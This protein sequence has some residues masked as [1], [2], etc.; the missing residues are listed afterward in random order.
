MIP[1]IGLVG[2]GHWSNRMHVPAAQRVQASGLARYAAV[3]DL[4]SAAAASGAASLDAR[5]Y[6]DLGKMFREVHPDGLVLVV[7]CATTPSLILEAARLKVPFLA[8]KPPAPD[9][10]VHRR[11]LAAVGNLP[12]MV[13][14][15][16]R[17]APYT[18]T[19]RAW[20]GDEV[21]QTVTAL[22]SRYR[23]R[24]E[25]FTTTAVHAIDAALFLATGTVAAARIEIARAGEVRNF[26][27]D[28][29]TDAHTRVSI[30][31]T[32]DTSTRQE[33][34]IVRGPTRSAHVAFPHPGMID[35]PGYVELQKEARTIARKTCT[36]YGI[37]E[38]DQPALAGV[39]AE[40]ERF[41]QMLCGKAEPIS[42]L[43]TSLPTQL[44][45]EQLTRQ[46]DTRLS[47]DWTP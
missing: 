45:R 42:T 26:F 18:T 25:D 24:S 46:T 14:Y 29:W 17:H 31:V 2:G 35:F 12:H 32:P 4:D 3:C 5:P 44:L 15:N 11:L 21:P 7:H 1:R 30:H 38:D 47:F 20:M 22:F 10:A 39:R 8:E 28:A 43:A 13:G 33:H 19:A 40:H 6:T 9:T 37:A 41:A 36:D 34:Y 16:R 23:R 27:I